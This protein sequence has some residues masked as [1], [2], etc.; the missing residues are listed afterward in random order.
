MCSLMLQRVDL[1]WENV[2]KTL[3]HTQANIVCTC[4]LPLKPPS[5]TGASQHAKGTAVVNT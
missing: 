5:A 2:A 4:C 1:F 3:A